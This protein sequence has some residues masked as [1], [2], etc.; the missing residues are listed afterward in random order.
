[1]YPHSNSYYARGCCSTLF[2]IETNNRDG[3]VCPEGKNSTTSAFHVNH[4]L[5]IERVPSPIP[6]YWYVG[7]A[8]G[9]PSVKSHQ[10]MIV[11][12]TIIDQCQSA[13]SHRYH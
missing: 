11:R 4:R 13:R 3:D 1:M 10:H 7:E 2:A 12:C 9:I 5:A 8:P 6:S